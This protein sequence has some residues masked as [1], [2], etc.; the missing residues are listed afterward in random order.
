MGSEAF[1]PSYRHALHRFLQAARD[2]RGDI[3]TLPVAGTCPAGE[4]LTIDTVRLGSPRASRLVVVSSGVHG[5]EGYFGSAVQLMFLRSVL[6]ALSRPDDVAVLLLHAVNPYGFAWDR[7]VSEDNVDINR[8]FPTSAQTYSGC[9]D[10]YEQVDPL[11]NPQTPPRWDCF[12]TRAA[13]KI[14]RHGFEPLKDNLK[15]QQEAISA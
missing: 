4:P 6:P 11:I 2:A 10:G 14:L 5:V 8:N 3:E 15:A 9:P 13:E 12:Y 7:R 1:S